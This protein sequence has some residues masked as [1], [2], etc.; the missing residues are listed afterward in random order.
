MDW[1]GD[2]GNRVTGLGGYAAIVCLSVI[3]EY[4]EHVP[5]LHN[6][7]NATK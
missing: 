2:G 6:D 3:L 7:T 5:V 1:A 4:S